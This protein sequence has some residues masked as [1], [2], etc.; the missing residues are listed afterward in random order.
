MQIAN[1]HLWL[2]I[3]LEKRPSQMSLKLKFAAHTGDL[4]FLADDL[5]ASSRRVYIVWINEN[6]IRLAT[7]V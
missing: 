1:Y 7:M 5:D 3:S 2:K 4:K 6:K